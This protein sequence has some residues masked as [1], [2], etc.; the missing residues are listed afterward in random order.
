MGVDT[1]TRWVL[2]RIHHFPLL[3]FRAVVNGHVRIGRSGLLGKN[4]S[5]RREPAVK[6]GHQSSVGIGVA[7]V[8]LGSSY[9]GLEFGF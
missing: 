5:R 7:A 3:D 4:I 1:L 6:T 2:F 9:W 8:G